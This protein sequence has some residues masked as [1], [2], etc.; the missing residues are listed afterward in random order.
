MSISD[1][2][3]AGTAGIAGIFTGFMT[4]STVYGGAVATANAAGLYGAAAIS[5][6]LASLGGGALAAGGA[7][8]VGGI[9][10]VA[11]SAALPALAVGVTGFYLYKKWTS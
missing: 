3:G 2:L 9:A 8:M 7:G 6:A 10:V 1:S 4:A 11:A 5:S